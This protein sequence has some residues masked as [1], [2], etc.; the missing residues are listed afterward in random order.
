MG[1]FPTAILIG[2][3]SA[4]RWMLWAVAALLCVLVVAQAYRGDATLPWYF[5]LLLAA[6]FV[7]SGWL[8]GFIASQL[9]KVSRRAN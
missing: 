9:L 2:C 1:P 5:T 3:L 6:S 7:V 8:S 4:L